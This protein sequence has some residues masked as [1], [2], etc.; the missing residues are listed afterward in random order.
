VTVGTVTQEELSLGSHSHFDVLFSFYVLLTT[1]HHTNIPCR[2]ERRRRG[3]EG[4]RERGG[5]EERE[6]GE[7]EGEGRRRRE[8]R[9]KR[10]EEGEMRGKRK[11]EGE[12]RGRGGERGEV[13]GEERRRREERGRG[14][15]RGEGKG[16]E[17]RGGRRVGQGRGGG[18][19]ERVRRERRRIDMYLSTCKPILFT[20]WLLA[21]SP[22]HA[23][24]LRGK[25]LFSRISRASVPSSIRS[26]LVRTPMV[27]TP[28]C[29]ECGVWRVVSGVLRVRC[30]VCGVL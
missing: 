10:G 28:V 12:E 7:V 23:P 3:R 14:G 15:G 9:R 22:T 18:E 4:R 16:R 26:N 8:E 2:E 25:T 6:G 13:K 11:R 24:R 21:P 30:M 19:R 17:R 29:C 5:G 20:T 1:V 27:R